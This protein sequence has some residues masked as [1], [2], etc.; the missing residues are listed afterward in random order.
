MKRLTRAAA[1]AIALTQ[2]TAFAAGPQAPTWDGLLSRHAIGADALQA[3]HPGWD[4]RGVVVAV[5]D[6]GVDVGAPGLQLTSDGKPKV[7][8]VRDASGEGTVRLVKARTIEQDGAPML[9]AGDRFVRGAATLAP[10]PTGALR[11]GELREDALAS[12]RAADLNADGDTDDVYSIVVW[13]AAGPQGSERWA[14]VDTDGDH[15]VSDEAPRRSY[16]VAQEGFTLQG[17]DPSR[18]QAPLTLGLF[19]PDGLTEVEVHFDD[20][21]HGTHCAGIAAGHAIDGKPGYDGIAPGAQV[22]SIKIGDNDVTGGATTTGAKKR[23]LE[24]AA[25]WAEDHHV[26]VVINLSY[27]IGSETEGASDID[28]LVDDTLAKHP[29]LFMAT[30]AGNNGPGISSVGQPG[31]S[32]VAFTAGAAL[33]REQARTIYGAR[34]DGDRIFWFS[35]RGA[36]LGKPDAVLPGIAGSTVPAWMGSGNIM[37]GTSMA[38]PQAAGAMAVILSAMAERGT[39]VNQGM[40]RRAL[41]YGARP[42]EGYT[43]LDQGGGLVDLASAIDV[44]SRLSVSDEARRVLAWRVSTACPTCDDGEGPGSYWR[45][46]GFVP[47]RGDVQVADITPIELAPEG[48]TR[49]DRQSLLVAFDVSTDAP[50]IDVVSDTVY[51]RGDTAAHV[52][53]ALRP[54]RLEEPGLYVGSVR[55]VAEGGPSGRPGTSFEVPV[56]VVVPWT[57]GPENSWTQVFSGRMEAVDVTRRFLRVPPAASTLFLDLTLTDGDGGSI[58]LHLFDPDGRAHETV[59]SAAAAGTGKLELRLDREQL[60][61]GIWELD[62]VAPERNPERLTYTLEARFT[63]LEATPVRVFTVPQGGGA[64]ATAEVTNRL[65]R[66][67]RGHGAGAIRGTSR[68]LLHDAAGDKLELPVRIDADTAA[69]D[70]TLR[71]EQ[72]E[73]ARFTDVSI[74]LVDAAGKAVVQDGFS[75]AVAHVHATPSPGDYTLVVQ[76]AGTADA[77]ESWSVEIEEV[78]VARQPIPITVELANKRR[79]TL[80][81]DVQAFLDLTLEQRPLQPPDGMVH[82]GEVKL[83][84]DED[85]KTWLTIPL[86]LEP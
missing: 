78:Y 25:D 66:P 16:E 28:R 3:A 31:G 48:T 35:S 80:W 59:G 22:L 30:S 19:L 42:I 70:L 27:G 74:A 10:A 53:F 82:H 5:L 2:A 44:A 83:V 76:A 68:T 58:D 39:P 17:F 9:R 8:A 73:Y 20:G 46:G 85:E 43:A 26:P 62:L 55:G 79:F 45:A 23:A 60:T 15:D 18:R 36:E 61:P 50:W 65:P 86:R 72:S 34:T 38:S 47:P 14:I 56:T 64:E 11:L 52:R 21:G 24:I 67:F 84:S 51:A 13:E 69:L 32:A 71:L 41:R 49:A 1:V 12:S 54:D 4:G 37:R 81:P 57:F 7:I 6:T 77:I 75:Q 33:V 63:G 29:L 40:L